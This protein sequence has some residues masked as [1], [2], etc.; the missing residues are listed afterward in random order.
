MH[1]GIFGDSFADIRCDTD[2]TSWGNL[3]IQSLHSHRSESYGHTGTSNWHNYE[4][5]LKNFTKYDAIVF[6]HTSAVRF[7]HL[8]EY[9]LGKNWQVREPF[10]NTELK[11]L[12]PAYKMLFSDTLLDFISTS[13]FNSVNDLC[14]KHGKYLIN[15]LCFSRVTHWYDITDTEFP[16]LD[17]L[18]AI[19]K[20]EKVIRNGQSISVIDIISKEGVNDSRLCHL[21][22]ENNNRFAT[23]LKNAIDNKQLN[24]HSNLIEEYDWAEY[25]MNTTKLY[26]R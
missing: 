26:G 6:C 8:P 18:S 23:I 20:Y 24:I 2:C 3:L 25:D 4:V 10:E 11:N 12:M 5:F 19:S 16:I 9:M 17:N 15:V 1:V 22:V 13:V 7:P 21:N 14:K